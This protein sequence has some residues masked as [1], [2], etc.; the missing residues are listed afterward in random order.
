MPET[1]KGIIERV[2]FHNPDNG[3]AVL[4]VKVKGRDDLVSVVGSTMSVTAG[5]H[6]EATG[7]WVIDREHGQ[8]FKAD[9]LKTTH[10][11]SAEGIEKYLASG[12]IR[13]IG[14]K[15]AAKIVSIY[16]ERTLEIFE[17]APDFLLHVKG[18]GA[19]R[20]KRIRKSWDEQKEVRK[21]TL[22][23]TE[24]GIT[25]GRAVRIYRTYG[26]E[27]I[28]KIKENPYQLAN[29]IRGIG[30]KTAD[31][32]A[33]TLGIDRNSPYRAKAAVRYTLQDLASQGHCGYPEP[34]VMEHANK[35]VEI[36]QKIISDA[37]RSV[38]QDGSVIREPV[39]G[40]PWLYLAGLYRAEVGLAQSVH[41]IASATPHPLP[42]F[43][44]EKAIAWVEQRL[45]IQLAAAQK[46][47]IR[48]ACQQKL[49]VITG[50]PGVGKTTLV[51]SIL[52]IFAAK[53][54][55]CVLAAPTG[56]AAKRLAET[57]GR[58]A[59]TVHRLLEFDPATGEFK[60]NAQHLLTGDL[61]VLDETSMV[62]VVLGHQVLRAIPSEACVI[63]VGDVDQLPSV[64]PGSV[65]A[66]LISSNVV[67]IVRLTEIFRQASE[68]RI[69]TAAYAINHGQMPNPSKSE[70]LT[71]FYFIE[72]NEPE[73]IQ[74]TLVRLVK[75][76]IPARFGFDPKSDIQVLTPMNRSVLG[77]RNL[78]Q[79]LQKAINPGDGGPEVQ[80][81]GWTFRIG[82][83]VIQ[84]VNN[85]DRDVF[86]GDLGIIEQI[87]RIEQVMTINFEG[88]LVEY[89]FGDLDEL[90]LAYV[91]SIHKSQ[92]SEFPC[93]VIPLHTQHYLMLQRNL[94]YTAVTRGKKLV[95]LVGSKKALNM[96][97]RR[98][99]TGQRYTALRKRLQEIG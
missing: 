78:N 35:L 54:L 93:I 42:R 24:H 62:D 47:A 91:L 53:E 64:G 33:A 17:Q 69:I 11:A 68:S 97:V 34:G 40:E 3:F 65:L 10:P 2:T 6:F 59:K 56:R 43:D 37:V 60:R 55:K 31:E 75:E 72:S 79:V 16:K 48:Q 18:I 67:P 73:G 4:R 66:D 32:L 36:E 20:L 82:D 80:R 29:D 63:L 74:D 90:A 52:E 46:E 13:S 41:R 8:Q 71:D 96:A 86:N 44:V 89:D 5:E 51:R 14:P 50:G 7:H 22:F 58:T 98:A 30:F 15:I 19:E 26:H 92:G 87:N 38:V 12:A 45:S 76:R 85:Y 39:E 9:E 77:A 28:A 25:S 99:D 49:L 61:F 23:L 27:S 21:I 81:F 1:L 57:T 70:E 83:R 84:T 88:R 94:L 95:V